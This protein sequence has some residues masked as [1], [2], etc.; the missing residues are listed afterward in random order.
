ML[1]GN[2]KNFLINYF[3]LSVLWLNV[4][5]CATPAW[6]VQSHGGAEGLVSHQ[7][8]HILFFISMV[9]LLLQQRHRRLTGP[10]W[11]EFKVFLILIILWNCL[12]FVGHW[13]REVVDM[14]KFVQDN[15]HTVGYQITNTF[16]LIFY[17]TR[18][19]HILLVPAFLYLLMALR[20]WDQSP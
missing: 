16:D 6:A 11:R 3:S 2:N 14:G 19:D 7:L 20:R 8:G 1:S 18:L 4:M 5:L 10:G 9:F 17:L 12:T 13:L 15:G